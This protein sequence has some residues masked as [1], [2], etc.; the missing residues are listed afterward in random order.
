MW[1]ILATTKSRV[2]DIF[3]CN[4]NCY[5]LWKNWSRVQKCIIW[6]NQKTE[7]QNRTKMYVTIMYVNSIAEWSL[8]MQQLNVSAVWLKDFLAE[9]AI[10]C[11]YINNTNSKFSYHSLVHQPL[12]CLIHLNN[13]RPQPVHHHSG[14]ARTRIHSCSAQQNQSRDPHQSVSE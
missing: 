10:L 3:L 12:I 6:W 14:R 11:S 7:R 1:Q 9:K 8:G 4:H 5:I 2:H 13:A